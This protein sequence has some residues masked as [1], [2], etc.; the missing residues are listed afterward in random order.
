MTQIKFIVEGSMPSDQSLQDALDQYHKLDFVPREGETIFVRKTV[1]YAEVR[2]VS[3]Q[4]LDPT[5]QMV[6]ISVTKR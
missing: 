4:L 6:E 5:N 3:H 2:K 1:Q